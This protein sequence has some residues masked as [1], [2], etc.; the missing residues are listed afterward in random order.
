LSIDLRTRNI[1]LLLEKPKAQ[2]A[3]NAGKNQDSL[4]CSGRQQ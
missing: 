3:S 1:R 2:K 4:H